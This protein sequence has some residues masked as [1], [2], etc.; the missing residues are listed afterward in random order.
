MTWYSLNE[1]RYCN[2]RPTKGVT[3]SSNGLSFFCKGVLTSLDTFLDSSKVIIGF[4][5]S[6]SF[7]NDNWYFNTSLKKKYP[8]LFEFAIN[9]NNN[10]QDMVINI[11]NNWSWNVHYRS[12]LIGELVA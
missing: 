1:S 12:N 3:S 8:T 11:N 9:K 5:N 7:W 2:D 6:I 10:F 4:G